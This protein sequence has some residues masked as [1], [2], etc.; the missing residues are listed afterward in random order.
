VFVGLPPRYDRLAWL[1]SFWQDRRWRAAVADAVVA[2]RPTLVL[3]VATGPAGVALAVASR[4][5]ATVVGVDLNEPMLR[6]GAA[7]VAAAGRDG[8]VRLVVGRGEQLPFPDGT[9]DA[10]SFSYLLRYV[11]DPAATV[12]ELARCLRPGGTMASLEF[13]VPPQPVWRVLWR[14]YVTA[15]LPLAGL[16]TGGPAWW[17]V[18]RFLSRSIPE[19]YAG[20]PLEEHVRAWERAGM[21]E[22]RTRVMS[23]GGGLVM[24]G[25]SSGNSS[26]DSSGNSSGDSSG[27]EA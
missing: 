16:L 20:F 5:T 27:D 21:R 9:F 14:L 22:V 18:G 1:L 26:G 3:D 8:Q 15:V 10:I 7:N 12:A 6:R 17:R 19:H 25:I 24:Q 23:V 2:S 13:F 11:E 4:S